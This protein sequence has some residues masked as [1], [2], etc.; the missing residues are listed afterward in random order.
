MASI[1]IRRIPT[2]TKEKLR[3]RAAR[4][5]QSLESYMR[6]VLHAAAENDVCGTTDLVSLAA[7]CFG[8]ENGVDLNL[9]H[10]GDSRPPISFD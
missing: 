4:S 7:M 2:S 5:G 9:P 8:K 3:Q 1:T 6:Q 10:R